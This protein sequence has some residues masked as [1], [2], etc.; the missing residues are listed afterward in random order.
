MTTSDSVLKGKYI[1]AVDDEEDVLETI[2]D[3]LDEVN[4]DKAIDYESASEKIRK[5][6]YDYVIL[7]IMGVE[8]LKLLEEAVNRGIPAIMLTAHAINPETLVESI[9]KGA[10]SY[11][12][13]ETLSDLDELLGELIEAHEKGDP[14]W[15]LLLEKFGSYYDERFGKDWKDK[16]KE[17]WSDF[18]KTYHVGKGIQERL[19]KSDK[20][21]GKGI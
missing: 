12:P 15:K 8:G 5:N 7:D 21:L 4:L 11:I 1:L 14:P 13:K 20:V 9:Q 17:F 18:S 10:I 19:L 3:V 16:E 2:E 6:K